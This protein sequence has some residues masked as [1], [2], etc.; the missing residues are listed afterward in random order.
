MSVVPS[1]PSRALQYGKA[2]RESDLPAG[3]KATCWALA[4]FA[5]NDTGKAWPSVKKLAKA[6]GLSEA[7]VS[8]HTGTAESKGY[9]H[10]QRRTNTS[11]M[12]TLTVPTVK[13]TVPVVENAPMPTPAAAA[14]EQE[15]PPWIKDIVDDTEAERSHEY[16]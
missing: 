13:A 10:K 3:T 14:P 12:Y 4:T 9:L 11:I 1:R 7:V 2:I 8:K 15:P 6:V 5:N 16:S